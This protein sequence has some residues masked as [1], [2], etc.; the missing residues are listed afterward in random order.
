MWA[1]AYETAWGAEAE[2]SSPAYQT[3]RPVPYEPPRARNVALPLIAAPESPVS[4]SPSTCASPAPQFFGIGI[5]PN[6]GLQRSYSYTYDWNIKH[7][8]WQQQYFWRD[9]FYER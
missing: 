5:G 6:P 8:F 4:D 3:P 1:Y 2:A 9:K 7:Q